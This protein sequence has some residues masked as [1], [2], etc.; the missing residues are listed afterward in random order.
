[1]G[2]VNQT[3]PI[4]VRRF[5]GP[6]ERVRRGATTGSPGAGPWVVPPVAWVRAGVST[7]RAEL[8]ALRFAFLVHSKRD[9][10]GAFEPGQFR[11]DSRRIDRLI[12][13]HMVIVAGYVTHPS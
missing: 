4:F 5:Y 1:M 10:M 8:R 7:P 6:V 12:Q 9:A 11:D 2:R 13:D 3:L